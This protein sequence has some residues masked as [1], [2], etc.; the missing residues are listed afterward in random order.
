MTT[1]LKWAKFPNGD[2]IG[3]TDGEGDL[4][5][6]PANKDR[7]YHLYWMLNV[8][9]GEAMDRDAFIANKL[10]RLTERTC[11]VGDCKESAEQHYEKCVRV[12]QEVA[13][14]DP[15]F[16]ESNGLLQS[17]SLAIGQAEMAA[18][19][20]ESSTQELIITEETVDAA[21]TP[22]FIAAADIE[23]DTPIAILPSIDEIEQAGLFWNLVPVE[24]PGDV[25]D[26]L[27]WTSKCG[28]YQA[29]RAVDRYAASG[30]HFG[31]SVRTWRKAGYFGWNPVEWTKHGEPKQYKKLQLALEAAA[32][33]YRADNK[34]PEAEDD[35]AKVLARAEKLG[36][37]ELPKIVLSEPKRKPDN[38]PMPANQEPKART[39]M[40]INE[41]DAREVLVEIGLPMAATAAKYPVTKLTERLNK[42]HN[43]LDDLAEPDSDKVK[44]I[45]K[46]VLAELKD[47]G[48]IVVVPDEAAD[49]EDESKDEAPAKE[50]KAASEPK[51]KKTA[52]KAA[53]AAKPSKNGEHGPSNKEAVYKLWKK[54]PSIEP[55]A[56]F[57]Q[58]N[59]AVKLTTIR[60][61]IN[62]WKNGSNLPACAK[63]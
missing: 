58:I 43:Q 40:K 37:L 49:A 2:W 62:Q 51:A 27:V 14:V 46:R 59:E 50:T 29:F 45:W 20:L 10:N 26:K 34:C 52:K 54:K 13:G 42:I 44:K 24:T 22:E 60:S 7:H 32:T 33:H 28:N 1:N 18:E 3:S 35:A 38:E 47:G 4:Y 25:T 56:A 5:C 53:T 8:D 19:L 17:E 31:A 23:A 11:S 36:V 12:G 9:S 61:W 55:Q 39:S 16:C 48:S 41:C 21:L 63:E 30:S 6:V 57:E 15:V